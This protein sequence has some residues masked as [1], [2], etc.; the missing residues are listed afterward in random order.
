MRDHRKGNTWGRDHALRNRPAPVYVEK[1]GEPCM[2][3]PLSQGKWTLI[4]VASYPLIS[5]KPWYFDRSGYA[6]RHEG[7]RWIPMHRVIAQIPEGVDTDHINR[8]RLDNRI[9][10]LRP[11]TKAQNNMNVSVRKDNLSGVRGVWFYKKRGRW[12][13]TIGGVKRRRY[14]GLFDTFEEAVAARKSAEE[15][16]F[17][18]FTPR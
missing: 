14:L 6:V 16:A 7:R 17:G 1:D 4:S 5:G 2:A 12:Q 11:A 9:S 3:I 10:N 13:A 18:Q 8:D 15:Q